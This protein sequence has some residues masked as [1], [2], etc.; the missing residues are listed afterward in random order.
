MPQV[1]PYGMCKVVPPPDWAPQPWA[2]RPPMGFTN[3]SPVAGKGGVATAPDGGIAAAVRQLS[4]SADG[5]E[6]RLAP[7]VQPLQL[8]NKG[9]EQCDSEMRLTTEEYHALK[10]GRA[11]V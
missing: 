6:P 3:I 9:F 10:I 4:P 1:E 8:F 7:R 11:H 2:G 5:S